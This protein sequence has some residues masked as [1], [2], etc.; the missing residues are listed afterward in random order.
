MVNHAAGMSAVNT[1]TTP[2]ETMVDFECK[3][4]AAE[5]TLAIPFEQTCPNCGSRSVRGQ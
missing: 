5:F 4:C 2:G 3:Q 1:E